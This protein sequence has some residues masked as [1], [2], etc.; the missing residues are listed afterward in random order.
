MDS[1]S[2]KV[3]T[4][5]RYIREHAPIT[6]KIGLVLGSGLGDFADALPRSVSLS[7]VDIPHYPVSSVEGHKGRL[8]FA[9]H[10]GQPLLA[11]QGRIHFYESNDT[12]SVLYPIHVANGLGIRTLVITN[13]AGG[14]N[15]AF[16]P[17]DLM[18]ITD[19]INLTG[20]KIPRPYPSDRPAI[21][22]YSLELIERV[23]R[24]ASENNI[25]LK[26]GVYAGLKGPSY[27]TASEIEMIHRLGGDA[28]GMSTV[29]EAALAVRFGMKVVGISCITNY[30]TGI[31]TLKLNHAEVTDVANRVKATFSNLI[32]LIVSGL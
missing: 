6:P 15:R 5:V 32:S 4:S 23:S 8:V 27:E 28:V 12:Y 3:A 31:A 30:A 24:L 11:F 10:P 22:V 18:L 26:R 7:T 17:G 2:E 16:N 14:I 20:L 29:L 1:F 13:A 9:V 19:Q 21:P 25:S